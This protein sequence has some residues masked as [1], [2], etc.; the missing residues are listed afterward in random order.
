MYMQYKF[1]YVNIILR[2]GLM[3]LRLH[4]A[5]DIKD[6]APV[7]SV[8]RV[9]EVLELFSLTKAPLT[10][11]QVTRRLGYP[12]S[13]ANVL[14]KS[15]VTLGYLTVE[16]DTLRYFPSLRITYLGDWISPALID[17]RAA[18]SLLEQL[19]ELTGETV[20]LS[21][22]NGKVMQFVKVL[23]GKFP[24]S[25]N[26]K[27][28]FT[29]PIF[30]TSVGAA[31]LSTLSKT[32]MDELYYRSRKA[33]D[34]PAG[35]AEYQNLCAEVARVRNTGYANLYNR[36]LPDT[37]AIAMPLHD[38]HLEQ[39]LIIGV[40]GLATRIHKMEHEIVR[41]IKSAVGSYR[42]RTRQH[43]EPATG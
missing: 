17:T 34:E 36:V 18:D 40:G 29:V 7:K 16:P 43:A 30:G 5:T 39:N 20:T 12:K 11:M 8:A 26:I 32:A 2:F 14:L 13:S 15:L 22:R 9:M 24:I 23:P 35:G 4:D 19:H 33:A 3:N 31:Y 42:R 25:L 28:G 38:R 27:R 6:A 10:C 37:G 21:M 1:I 41:F